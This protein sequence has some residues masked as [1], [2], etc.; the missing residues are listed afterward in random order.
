[1]SEIPFSCFS[2]GPWFRKYW[3]TVTLLRL[4]VTLGW[5]RAILNVIRSTC[6]FPTM[7][8]QNVCC[9]KGLQGSKILLLF[10]DKPLASVSN[11]ISYSRFLHCI[12]LFSSKGDTW[13]RSFL[14]IFIMLNEYLLQHLILKLNPLTFINNNK[15]VSIQRPLPWSY[16]NATSRGVYWYILTTIRCE[17]NMGSFRAIRIWNSS[18]TRNPC[19]NIFCQK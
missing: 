1:M 7:T 16:L 2:F 9:I 4:T 8:S 19:S 12:F 11:A 6:A 10:P 18:M 17:S 5:N 3:L 13:C 15:C 14:S